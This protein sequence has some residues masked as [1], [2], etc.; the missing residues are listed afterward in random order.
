MSNSTDKTNPMDDYENGLITFEELYVI[1]D[2]M[3][4]RDLTSEEQ[5]YY[6]ALSEKAERGEFE[7]PAD[8]KI[9][10]GEEAK[11]QGRDFIR[12]A[13]EPQEIP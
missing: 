12:R 1:I 11:K 4:K 10:R 13:L 8:A 7:I 9:W 2:S 3:P 6:W 5:A